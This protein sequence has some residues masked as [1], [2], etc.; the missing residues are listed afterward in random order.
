MAENTAVSQTL[1]QLSGDA[2]DDVAANLRYVIT[3]QTPSDTIYFEILDNTTGVITT[4][5]NPLNYEDTDS[6]I[7]HVKVCDAGGA[8]GCLS[9]TALVYVC[10]TDVNELAPTFVQVKIMAKLI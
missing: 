5:N 2:V 7:L 8:T 9:S 4:T 10:V 1:T 3:K 6:V